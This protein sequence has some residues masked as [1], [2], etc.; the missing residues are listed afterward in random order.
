MVSRPLFGPRGIRGTRSSNASFCFPHARGGHRTQGPRP[1]PS[2]ADAAW[3]DSGQVVKM[4]SP[5]PEFQKH[6]PGTRRQP[7]PGSRFL[8]REQTIRLSYRT[9]KAASSMAARHS[10]VR[11]RRLAPAASRPRRPSLP[12]VPLTRPQVPV[13]FPVQ[14]GGGGP[15]GKPL[16]GQT[17]KPAERLLLQKT[18]RGGEGRWEGLGHTGAPRP[19]RP[20]SRA[21]T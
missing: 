11:P 4:S 17:L 18:R 9:M 7:P 15:T 10:P 16:S 20:P 1:A 5:S 2:A 3:S 13:L 14:D 19:G 8:L 6:P 12:P 21:G